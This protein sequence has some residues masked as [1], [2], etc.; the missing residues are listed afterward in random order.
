MYGRELRQ[1]FTLYNPTASSSTSPFD[2]KI[3]AGGLQHDIALIFEKALEAVTKAKKQQTGQYDSKH[4][5][6]TFNKGDLVWRRNFTQ[7]QAI[8]GVSAKLLPKYVGPYVISEVLSPTQYALRSLK[9]RDD[10]RWPSIHLK[11]VV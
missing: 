1:C 11:A 10:G 5:P 8:A 9:G 3:Y 4:K 2:A 6:V 7:S